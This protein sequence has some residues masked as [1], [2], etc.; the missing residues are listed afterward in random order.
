MTENSKKESA[1]LVFGL[2]MGILIGIFIGNCARQC[3][4]ERSLD[5]GDY[6]NESVSDTGY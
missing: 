5:N 6:Y 2:L 4:M 1:A 3:D